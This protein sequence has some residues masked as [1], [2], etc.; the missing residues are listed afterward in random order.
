M[1][2]DMNNT[3]KNDFLMHYGVK[4]M[5][6]GVRHDP[7]PGTRRYYRSQ[8]KDQKKAAL[9]RMKKTGQRLT[10]QGKQNDMKSVNKMVNRYEKDMRSAK[11]AYKHNVSEYKGV[12]RAASAQFEKQTSKLK[13]TPEQKKIAKRI[14][15]GAAVVAG[16]SLAAYG[17]VKVAEIHNIKTRNKAVVARF[18]SK[19]AGY[20]IA[21]R[22]GK[23]AD[24]TRISKTHTILKTA[25]IK[26]T[27]RG[28]SLRTTRSEVY[29]NSIGS[30]KRA[31]SKVI[32][33][34][35]KLYHIPKSDVKR[36]AR[37]YDDL[38]RLY[39]K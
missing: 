21:V 39:T 22:Y 31:V 24:K 34:N 10:A 32:G 30:G 5:K 7:Q 20:D 4:G 11:D 16:V 33:A 3:K 36:Y 37:L 35:G 27:K 1:V 17:G 15:I 8:Y 6:W 25:T 28:P 2:D 13:M 14:A 29:K 38:Y 9:N 18:L 26:N 19:N 12:A 23:G